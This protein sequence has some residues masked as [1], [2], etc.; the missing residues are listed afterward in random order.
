MD[1]YGID[2]AK[3]IEDMLVGELSKSI[4]ME[5]MRKIRKGG[6]DMLLMELML[7][8]IKLRKNGKQ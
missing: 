7:E 2:L 8:K 5:I 1:N 4:D 3:D 6:V